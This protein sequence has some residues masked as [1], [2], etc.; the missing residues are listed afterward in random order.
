M[1]CVLVRY[2]T[3]GEARCDLEDATYE[4]TDALSYSSNYGPKMAHL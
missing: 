2:V 3:L 4:D 1:T